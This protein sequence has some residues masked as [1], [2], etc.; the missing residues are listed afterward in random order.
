[1][2][3]ENDFIIFIISHERAETM[4]TYKLL[5]KMQC[6]YPIYIVIDSEDKQKEL[7]EKMYN[8]LIVFDKEKYIEKTDTIDNFKKRTSAVYARNFCIDKAKEMKKR[9]FAILDDDLKCFR[10]RYDKNGVLK[11]KDHTDINKIF[12]IY[13]T[14]LGCSQNIGGIG[15]RKS[16]RLHWWNKRTCQRRNKK[17]LQS[18][19]V[20][21]K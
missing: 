4:T 2:K 8:S 7:Y 19:Y 6:K 13:L 10:Q 16:W 17:R 18:S 21:K 5:Q 15:M 14:F 20:A 3:F 1:M 11:T 9:F 12:D